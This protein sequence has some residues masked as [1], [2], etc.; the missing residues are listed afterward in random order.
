MCTDTALSLESDGERFDDL[1]GAEAALL[2]A[3]RVW[4]IGHY[5]QQDMA[6]RIDA[7]WARYGIHG[8]TG[9]LEGFMWALSRGATRPIAV[10]C[11]CRTEVSADE[12]CLLDAF[13]ALQQDDP[14]ECH[15]LLGTLV[16][17]AA[18]TVAQRS[19]TVLTV[20][21]EQAGLDLPRPIATAGPAPLA[22][23]LH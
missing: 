19:A 13:A 5:R 3:M 6:P 15:D 18:A 9:Y 2:W 7:A 22:R 21:L 12:R 4:V 11:L 1:R 8:G 14:V 17:D 16:S 10:L 23:T 20:L